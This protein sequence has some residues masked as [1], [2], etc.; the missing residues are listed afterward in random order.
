MERDITIEEKIKFL[1]LY[2][3]LEINTFKAVG[4]PNIAILFNKRKVGLIMEYS[5]I[6]F[7]PI[8]LVKTILIINPRNLVKKPPII[9][10]KVDLT[11]LFFII[12]YI[13][14]KQK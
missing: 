1:L 6:P 13:N 12:N 5:P 7:V 3:L 4:S 10:I 9:S 14:N 8:N 11:N 2:L